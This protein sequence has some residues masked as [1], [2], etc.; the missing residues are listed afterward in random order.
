M[1][2]FVSFD[3]HSETPQRCR[4]LLG[5]NIPCIPLTLPRVLTLLVRTGSRRLE[6]LLVPKSLP[7]H[8]TRTHGIWTPNALIE[9]VPWSGIE[10][11]IR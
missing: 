6:D 9:Y 2:N 11:Q 5:A 4:Y 10:A 7:D 3:F 8:V 1:F